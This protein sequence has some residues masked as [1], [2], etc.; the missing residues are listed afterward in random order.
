MLTYLTNKQKSFILYSDV[1]EPKTKSKKMKQTKT[2]K[3][4]FSPKINKISSL[5]SRTFQTDG[6]TDE[7]IRTRYKSGNRV[8]CEN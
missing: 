7:Y 3:S 1:K 5:L 8:L 4:L 2:R 6:R